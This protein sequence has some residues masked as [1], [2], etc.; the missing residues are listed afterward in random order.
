[1]SRFTV[2]WGPDAENQLIEIWL[3]ADD[4]AD[5]TAAADIYRR[6]AAR[7]AGRIGDDMDG[8]RKPYR[9]HGGGE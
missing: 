9:R 2:V 1:M 7:S 5:V 4:R 8:R 6:M 3:A